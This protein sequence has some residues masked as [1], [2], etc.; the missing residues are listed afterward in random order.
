MRRL[1][2]VAVVVV[3]TCAA[4][5]VRAE[6]ASA[7]VV[8]GAVGW[9][10]GLAGKACNVV[11]HG[12][13]LLSAGKKLAT[14]HVGGAVQT[15]LGSGGGGGS[16]ATTALGLAAIG[17]WVVGG[18]K[19]ALDG[20]VKAIG[21]TTRPQLTTTWFSSTY[22]RM[23]GIAAVLTLP[24]LFAAAVQALLRSDLS[25]LARAAFGYLPLSVLAVSIAAPLTMLL[26]TACDQM[27]AIVS[28]AGARGGVGFLR[29]L[30]LVTGGL[31]LAAHSPFLV[32]LVGV[33]MAAGAICLWIEM[34]AR[35]A[36]VYIVVLML[37]LA[38][39]AMVWPARRVWAVRTAEL[40]VALI[41]SKFAI[42]AVLALGGAA[43]GRNG[44]SGAGG[45]LV[46]LV[47]VML[48]ALAP[49][50]LVRLLPLAELASG[51]A[52]QLRGELMRHGG[53]P[54]EKLMVAAEGADEWV[55]TVSSAMR[56]QAEETAANVGGSARQNGAATEVEKL[57]ETRARGDEETAMPVGEG[58]LV[59]VGG[60]GSENGAP[61]ASSDGA[62]R[63]VGGSSDA[64]AQPSER[65]EV[66]IWEREDDLETPWLTFEPDGLPPRDEWPAEEEPS[67]DETAVADDPP[68]PPA[69]EPE[70]GRL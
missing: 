52:G 70:D 39:A 27:S 48:G 21:A 4:G 14:G 22:W 62:A 34:L 55:S 53:R 37:P 51:A 56:R 26:L 17:A 16:K 31:S 47:L 5:C 28:S 50:A 30:G 10:S 59:G 66:Q 65:R 61:T 69:Q 25:L 9:V 68:S 38:F 15:V 2:V 42:V 49:W 36:A 54:R 45:M 40:L 19:A 57:D 35:E 63:D 46:G 20:A 60:G 64:R 67:D 41:L 7:S 43:L 6:T 24:F 32:F 11:S 23:A 12:D 33:L 1:R 58:V 44:A 3:V 29:Q 13:Q 8:C 18:A